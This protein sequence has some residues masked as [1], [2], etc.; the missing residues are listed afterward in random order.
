MI[1]QK[2]VHYFTVSTYTVSPIR[3][4]LWLTAELVSQNQKAYQCL[5]A[6]NGNDFGWYK[7]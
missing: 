5:A 6:S 4:L 3:H 2:Y 7:E 1:F